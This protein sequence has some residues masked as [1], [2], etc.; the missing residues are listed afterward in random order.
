[1][2]ASETEGLLL[3]QEVGQVLAERLIRAAHRRAAEMGVAIAAAVVDRGGRIVAVV[4]MDGTALCGVPIA[5][6][7]AYSAV[8]CAAP[9]HQWA[10]STMPGGAD[11]GMST[12]LD[13]RMVVY[14]GGMPI[15]SA[16]DVVG[17]LGVSG[18]EGH[19]DLECATAA[20]ADHGLLP[21]SM[22]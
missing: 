8:A 4:R 19:Q 18:A 5:I 17:G 2:Q 21:D 12:A 13:G 7:K 6:D 22:P 3:R 11:W 20:L 1:M 16:G 10:E 9:T 15:V 14:P